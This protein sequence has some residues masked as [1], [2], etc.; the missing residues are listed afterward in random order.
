MLRKKEITFF[1]DAM[2]GNIAKKLRLLGY[3]SKYFS[4][5][6]DEQL[7]GIAKKEDRIIISKDEYLIKK[8]KKLGMKP[9]F[10]IQ[11]NE[12][13]Q[14]LEIINQVK[15]NTQINDN[16]AR[17]SKCNSDT[18]LVDKES[19][20]EKVPQGV[21][22]INEKFWRCRAC[23]QIYWEGTH[24]KNLQKFLGKINERLQ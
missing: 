22:Y 1:V 9:I 5:I 14:F 23:D 24:I 8:A 7:I 6:D 11:N 16:T 18:E 21:Y 4:D 3:D 10:L 19:I 17:C 13:E 2:L 12:I 20:K 15:V